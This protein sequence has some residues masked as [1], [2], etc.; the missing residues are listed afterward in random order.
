MGIKY[1]LI[2]YKISQLSK[3]CTAADA[4]ETHLSGATGGPAPALGGTDGH[5]PPWLL[6]T[7]SASLA[8]FLAAE[9]GHEGRDTAILPPA[10]PAPRRA[11][12]PKWHPNWSSD[13]RSGSRRG[14]AARL[15]P[16]SDRHHLRVRKITP[17]KA[18]PAT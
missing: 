6:A 18:P 12:Y 3:V 10:R 15:M 17:S 14:T 2:I 16:V 7:L 8:P 1:Q 11:A 9:D 5:R 13:S 4:G